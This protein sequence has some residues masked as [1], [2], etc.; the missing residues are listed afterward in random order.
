MARRSS[1]EWQAIIEQ[2]EASGLSVVDF[3]NK[4]Q[5]DYKYFHAR[6]RTLL[7]RQQSKLASPFI[8]VSRALPG[9]TGM[10]L[11]LGDAKLS[12]LVNTEPDWSAQLLKA[13]SV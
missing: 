4:Q 6:K 7:K 3:C 2:H 11:Q 1:Q 13:L 10:P 12:L 9:H 8:K 5:L